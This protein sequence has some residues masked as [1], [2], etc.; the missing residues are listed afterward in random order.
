MPGPDPPAMPPLESGQFR[1]LGRAAKRRALIGTVARSVL[2]AATILL[3]YYV[4]PFEAD[5]DDYVLVRFAIMAVLVVA[6]LALQLRGI[7]KAR[8]PVLRAVEGLALTV[9]L[10]VV[11]F[12]STYLGLYRSDAQAFSEAL[13][14]TGSLYF[15][16]TTLS[17][18]GYGDIAPKSEVARVAVMVQMAANVIVVGAAAKLIVGTAKRAAAR[19]G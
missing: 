4:G 15:T 6:V 3:A 13:D 5:Q 11:G 12:A 7:T 16:M 9:T 1:E 10:V 18:V 2:S 19:E 8:F 14:H 17:T